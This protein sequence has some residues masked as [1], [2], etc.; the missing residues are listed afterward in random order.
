MQ[1]WQARWEVLEAVYDTLPVIPCTVMDPFIGS[2][3]TAIVSLEHGRRCWGIDLSERYL[4]NNAI[5]RIEG[6]LLNRP[7]MAHLAGKPVEV[8]DLGEEI[9]DGVVLD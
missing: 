9:D 7:S 5:L 8:L 1:A 3:T 4:R 6:E 2:G